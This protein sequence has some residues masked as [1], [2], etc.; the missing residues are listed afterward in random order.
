MWGMVQ[1]AIEG[2]VSGWAV[3]RGAVGVYLDNTGVSSFPLCVT[4]SIVQGKERVH[5]CV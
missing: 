3:L 2:N 5:H 1:A 4:C